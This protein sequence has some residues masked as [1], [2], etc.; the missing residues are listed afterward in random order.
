[1]PE[2][3]K[4]MAYCEFRLGPRNLSDGVAMRDLL[5]ASKFRLTALSSDCCT[6]SSDTG[7]SALLTP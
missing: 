3:I 4:I 1:M 5:R 7:L 6:I 2:S